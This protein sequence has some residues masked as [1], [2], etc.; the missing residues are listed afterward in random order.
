MDST[1]LN[2]TL[3]DLHLETLKQLKYSKRNIDIQ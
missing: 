3:R 1:Y 2:S